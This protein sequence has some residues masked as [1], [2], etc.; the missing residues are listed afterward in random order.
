MDQNGPHMSV[1]IVPGSGTGELKGISG[2]LDI[3][4]AD[5]RHSYDLKYALPG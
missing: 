3:Q 5:G 4:I 1:I 2:T